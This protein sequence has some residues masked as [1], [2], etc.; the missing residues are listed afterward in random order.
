MHPQLKSALER[1]EATGTG[2]CQICGADGPV[3]Y[4]PEAPLP[5]SF[6]EKCADEYGD[7]LVPP[8]PSPA[9]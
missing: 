4:V 5:N 8:E 6:C 7:E 1:G 9:P 3:I 2:R